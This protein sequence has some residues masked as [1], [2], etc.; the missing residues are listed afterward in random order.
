MNKVS[1]GIGGLQTQESM[2]VLHYLPGFYPSVE[3]RHNEAGNSRTRRLLLRHEK[4]GTLVSLYSNC[5]YRSE[6]SEPNCD[7]YY[8]Y[9]I[10]ARLAGKGKMEAHSHAGI[11]LRATATPSRVG[12]MK[13][14]N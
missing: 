6:A 1:F 11:F 14:S 12:L 13:A 3:P 5:I 7:W 2:Y 10:L 8:R 9:A 4:V